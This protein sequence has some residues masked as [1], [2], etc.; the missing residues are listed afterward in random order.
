MNK[1]KILQVIGVVADVQFEENLPNIYTAL[2][3]KMPDGKEL[4]ELEE[5]I[6]RAI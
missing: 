4:V 2:T 1:G 5:K 6:R 3:T